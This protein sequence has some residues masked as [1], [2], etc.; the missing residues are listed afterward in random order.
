MT[1]FWKTFLFI[2]RGTW[3]IGLLDKQNIFV[4]NW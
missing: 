1:Q 2:D 3:L 4:V